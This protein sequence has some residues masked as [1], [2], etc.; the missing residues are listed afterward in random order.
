MIDVHMFDVSNNLYGTFGS[1]I[2]AA[3][4]DSAKNKEVDNNKS[5]TIFLKNFLLKKQY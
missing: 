3:Y 5:K 2:G 1:C 4:V